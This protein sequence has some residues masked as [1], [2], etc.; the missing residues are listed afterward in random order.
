M[1]TNTNKSR[2]L[3][4]YYVNK[5]LEYRRWNGYS[6]KHVRNNSKWPR[7]VQ[8][9]PLLVH[10]PLALSAGDIPIDDQ[11]SRTPKLREAG[12]T[13]HRSM[14]ND[15][16]LFSTVTLSNPRQS[17]HNRIELSFFFTNNTGAP[18]DVTLG[19]MNPQ[20]RNSSSCSFNC[21]SSVGAEQ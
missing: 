1:K 15:T 18:H 16:Y 12:R 3:V 4:K 14:A 21:L 7:R 9:Y 19:R 11:C 20:S 10:L 6:K 5:L 17:I 8:I 13:S 2:C